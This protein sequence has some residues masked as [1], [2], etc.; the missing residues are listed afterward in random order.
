M[1]AQMSYTVSYFCMQYV[2]LCRNSIHIQHLLHAQTYQTTSIGLHIIIYEDEHSGKSNTYV[3]V[4]K[5]VCVCMFFLLKRTEII[6]DRRMLVL[7]GIRA[8]TKIYLDHDTQTI[9]RNT[10]GEHVPN[11]WQARARLAL[12][13]HA[14][15]R[16]PTVVW[17][18]GKQLVASTGSTFLTT[19]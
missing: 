3:R 9:Q 5:L 15:T 16:R 4:C 2:C 14:R 17:T 8:G 11:N 19:I 18:F 1:C 10:H 13:G 12:L 6:Q 7:I